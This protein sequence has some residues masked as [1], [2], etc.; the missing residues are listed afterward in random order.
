MPKNAHSSWLGLRDS[1]ASRGNDMAKLGK[2]RPSTNGAKPGW[3]LYRAMLIIEGFHKFRTEGKNRAVSQEKT[4]GYV[5]SLH[6]RMPVSIGTVKRVL[7]YCRPRDD[8][9]RWVVNRKK[10]VAPVW[11]DLDAL[12]LG[13]AIEKHEVLEVLEFSTGKPPKYPKPANKLPPINF[14]KKIR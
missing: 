7:A 3:M 11:D 5:K 10:V 6:P 4:V 8:A 14:S 2:G 13:S 1:S 9:E 12:A